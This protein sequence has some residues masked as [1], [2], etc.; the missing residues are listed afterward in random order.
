MDTLALSHVGISKSTVAFL[1][2]AGVIVVGVDRRC[3]GR[4]PEVCREK[5]DY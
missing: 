2:I 3:P 5:Q 1:M 4:T